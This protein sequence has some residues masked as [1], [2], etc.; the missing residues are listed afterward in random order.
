MINYDSSASKNRNNNDC[1]HHDDHNN[2]N[3]HD[4]TTKKSRRIFVR[5]PNLLLSINAKRHYGEKFYPSNHPSIHLC[6]CPPVHP[7]PLWLALRPCWL[8]LRPRWLALLTLRACWRG[9]GA[10]WR[11]LRAGWRGLRA[12]WR[13]LRASQQGLRASRQGLRAS[14]QGLRTSQRGDGQTD[15]RTFGIS[16]HSTGLCPLSGPL[17]K[18][19]QNT[20]IES[21]KKGSHSSSGAVRE[22]LNGRRGRSSMNR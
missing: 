13:G 14:R 5:L 15:G 9:L 11:G 18:N 17:P 4:D 20:V 22:T 7:P 12:G 19:Q 21:I 16:P 3:N 2:H 1:D 6:I 10:G 8:A